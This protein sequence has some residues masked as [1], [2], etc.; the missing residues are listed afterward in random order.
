M[1]K[2]RLTEELG[3]TGINNIESPERINDMTSEKLTDGHMEGTIVNPVVDMDH[4]TD[5]PSKEDDSIN[6]KPVNLPDQSEPTDFVDNNETKV[7]GETSKI[8]ENVNGESITSKIEP[9]VETFVNSHDTAL[10]SSTDEQ[11]THDV[12]PIVEQ[13]VLEVGPDENLAEETELTINKEVSSGPEDSNEDP[14]EE[15]IEEL[16][17]EV[18]IPENLKEAESTVE[19][20]LIDYRKCC[21]LELQ[22]ALVDL[23]RKDD[24]AAIGGTL[25]DI[26]KCFDQIEKGEKETALSQFIA[27]GG[28]KDDFKFQLD[29]V[30]QKLLA[31]YQILR[32][33]RHKYYKQLDRQKEENLKIKNEI[34]EELREMVDGEESTT[35]IKV[36]NSIRNKWKNAGPIPRQFHKTLW[37]NYNALMDRFYDNRSI[38][39]ELK[40]LDR[41]KNLELK[42]AL[43]V[44]AEDLALKDD[45][46]MAIIDLNNLHDDFKHIGPVPQENQEEL[47]LRFKAASDA[48]YSKRKDYIDQIKDQLQENLIVKT[49]LCDQIET[50]TAF[51][52]DRITTWN[53]KTKEVQELQKKWEKTGGL[54]RDKSKLVNRRFW[55]GFK[56]FFANKTKFFKS[57]EGQK[58]DNLKLKEALVIRAEELKSDNDFLKTAETFKKLQ[59]EWR[60][61]GPVPDRLKNDVYKRFKANCDA[62]FDKK[63]ASVKESEKEFVENLK[64]KENVCSQLEEISKS[65]K[66]DLD[67]VATLQTQYSG[68]GF[69]PRKDIK[70]MNQRYDDVLDMLKVKLDDSQLPNREQ[71]SLEIEIRKLKGRP[72]ADKKIERQGHNLRRQIT[73]IENDISTWK[74]NL[75]FFRA[76]KTT[77]RLK[78]EFDVKIATASEELKQLKKQLRIMQA[79]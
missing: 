55:S 18:Q 6:S 9:V 45:V 26:K 29:E 54:P 71:L 51:S 20:E 39:F 17:E 30:S 3:S 27:D 44:K 77:N 64:R 42:I 24:I 63:R 72:G 66:I 56:L 2:E 47:W 35:S 36:I 43:C 4:Q 78:K 34:L 22:E 31:N 76:S 52:S 14:S 48:V 60:E 79:V 41:K 19:P 32:D 28:D 38:Y 10:N 49:E 65:D 1:D 53:D 75:E 12:L 7:S 69:V 67:I 74:N 57:L 37:A 40:E 68:I 73:A 15:T 21:K 61:V 58:E 70:R 23:V 59:Q 46:K 25:N 13:V 16:K 5:N 11:A 62:F 8:N 50:L 33:R